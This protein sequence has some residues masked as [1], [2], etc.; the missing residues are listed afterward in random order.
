[1]GNSMIGTPTFNEITLKEIEWRSHAVIA[2]ASQTIVQVVKQSRIAQRTRREVLYGQILLGIRNLSGLMRDLLDL[3]HAQNAIMTL[4]AATPEERGRIVETIR[5]VHASVEE[6]TAR[7][8]P[9]RHWRKLYRLYVEKIKTCNAEL[10]SHAN[11]FSAIGS[12]LILLT[13]NDQD[14]LMDALLRPSEPNDALRRAF[15][16]K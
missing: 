4:E 9:T 2:G 5:D 15:A 3:F 11:A 6:T 10:E 16:R 12:Q 7:L 1:M 14:Q 8:H 13:K